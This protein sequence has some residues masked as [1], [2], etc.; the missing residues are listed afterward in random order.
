VWLL[1]ALW[2]ATAL[3]GAFHHH[4]HSDPLGEHCTLCLALQTIAMP[5][6][7][8]VLALFSIPCTYVFVFS[9][10]MLPVWQCRGCI[11]LRSPPLSS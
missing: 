7:A 10:D 2:L 8:L 4:D 9:N 6:L 5:L 11:P 3:A 1:A